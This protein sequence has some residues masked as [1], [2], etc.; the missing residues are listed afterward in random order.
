MVEWGRAQVNIPFPLTNCYGGGDCDRKVDDVIVRC[1]CENVSRKCLN[2]I[3]DLYREINFL[4]LK[5]YLFN[6][7]RH[8]SLSGSNYDD[9]IK[10]LN[11]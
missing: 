3:G 8:Q 4:M 7:C 1:C 5:V 10:V 11:G 6:V 2:D 9:L